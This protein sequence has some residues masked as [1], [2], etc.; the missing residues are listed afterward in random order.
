[1][2]TRRTDE[3][4]QLLLETRGV[5]K[6]FPGVHALDGVSFQL[7]EGEVHA[8]VGE[9]GAGKSTL[10]NV[11]SGMIA[12]D[13][14][15]VLLD[16]QPVQFK[17]RLDAARQGIGIVFQELSLAYGLSVAENVFAHCQPVNVLGLIRF[18]QLFAQ[19][20][21]LLSLFE[22]ETDPRALIKD[23]S[24][25]KQQVVEILKALAM[26]PRILILDE[27][28]SSLTHFETRKLFENIK[29]LKQLGVG[30]IYISHHIQEIFEIADRATVLRDGRYVDT[31]EIADTTEDRIVG[32]MVGRHVSHAHVPRLDR[33]RYE[34][35]VLRV[36]NLSHPKYF[37]DVSFTVHRGEILCFSGLIGAGRSE[38][39]RAIFGLE[40]GVTGRVAV[41]GREVAI[42]SPIDA[43]SAGI[44]Y[45]SENRKLEGLFLEMNVQE[46]IVVPRLSSFATAPFGIL[47]E[48][49]MNNYARRGVT[50]HGVV[51]HSV[52]Q[53]MRTLSGG[54]QQKILL[55]MWLGID[56]KVIIVDEPTKGVDVGAKG[57]IYQLLRDLADAGNA[58]LVISSDLL[59]VLAIADRIIVVRNGT[60]V[61]SLANAEAT[62]QRIIALATGVD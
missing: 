61:Q 45:T 35:P 36:E 33:I 8:L 62:E 19:T 3:D 20:R 4:R 18:P 42:R 24:I 7:R 50:D 2:T 41:E 25:A 21:A 60:L 30:V 6:R 48:R 34:E 44:V 57:E 26:E 27:P 49:A 58:I 32:L 17:D 16:G 13:E 51:T 37:R 5:S 12:P 23:L 31:V 59:E 52:R 43:M 1:M 15:Q 55:A 28:T 29:R 53:K 11:L 46:N 14:G 47:S 54:N 38:I 9:N 39:A 40:R 10:M 56:P 22:D